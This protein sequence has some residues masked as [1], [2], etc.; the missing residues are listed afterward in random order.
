MTANRIEVVGPLPDNTTPSQCLYQAHPSGDDNRVRPWRV[1]FASQSN[2]PQAA[3]LYRPASGTTPA[4]FAPVVVTT[5]GTISS[6]ADATK[7]ELWLDLRDSVPAGFSSSNGSQ[8]ILIDQRR[9]WVQDSE[10]KLAVAGQTNA[11]AQTVAFDVDSLVLSA[12][13]TNPTATVTSLAINGPWNRLQT[14]VAT[15]KAR[16]GQGRNAARTFQAT[17]YPRNVAS[18]AAP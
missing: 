16:S 14:V 6:N 18:E 17:V 13:L 2:A 10:L 11:Q 9:Y 5:I 4:A 8:L 3:L 12:T 15:L 1:F 7:R